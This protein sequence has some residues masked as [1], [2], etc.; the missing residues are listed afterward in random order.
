M[1]LHINWWIPDFWTINRL[2]WDLALRKGCW[3]TAN[4][5]S[6][7]QCW[8]PSL[9]Q[10]PNSQRSPR[11]GWEVSWVSQESPKTSESQILSAIISLSQSQKLCWLFGCGSTV[12]QFLAS[13]EKDNHANYVIQC[14]LERGRFE[15][16]KQIVEAGSS[17][18][19]QSLHEFTFA[20]NSVRLLRKAYWTLPR[21]RP[22]YGHLP[23]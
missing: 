16:K 10:Q 13:F 18:G 20:D 23:C 5:R 9:R 19:A 11:F 12:P 4:W 15:D 2:I 7:R 21:T 1:I 17:D 3:S 8:I 6:C 14:I 22:G